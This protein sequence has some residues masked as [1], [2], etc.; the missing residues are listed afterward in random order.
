MIHSSLKHPHIVEML[1]TFEDDH[2][3]YFKMEL[4]KGGVSTIRP[5]LQ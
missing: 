1:D 3:V 5:P 4:C 2:H